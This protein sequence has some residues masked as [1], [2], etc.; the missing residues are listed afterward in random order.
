MSQSFVQNFQTL[1]TVL[2][3]S[4]ETDILLATPLKN[5]GQMA[6]F[7]RGQV[8]SPLLFRNA[9]LWLSEI[10]ESRFYRPDLW[11]YLDPVV[12]CEPQRVRL[13]CFSSCASVYGRVDF[14]ADFFNGYALQTRGTTHVNFNPAFIKSLSQLRPGQRAVLEVG[15]QFLAL[16]TETA[17]E[18]EVKVTLS[19]RW[20]RGFLQSQAL[21]RRA[22]LWKSL[23][24]LAARQFLLQL[25]ASDTGERCLCLRGAQLQSLPIRPTGLPE[26]ELLEVSG[27]HRLGLFRK[28]IPHLQSLDIYQTHANGPTLWVAHLPQ[29]RLTLALSSTVKHGFSGEGEA[30]RSLSQIAP[31]AELDFLRMLVAG[32]ESFTLEELSQLAEISIEQSTAWVDTLAS[33]GLLGFDNHADRYFYRVLPFVQARQ[34]RLENSQALF[35][36]EK[37]SLEQVLAL[38]GGL[39][40]QGWIQGQSAEYHAELALQGGYL[41]QGNCT[42]R[43]IQRHGLQRGPCKHLLALRF[44][45]EAHLAQVSPP[46]AGEHH[47]PPLA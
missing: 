36:Q 30:L 38:P 1:S 22:T 6:Q 43:W 17:R 47:A 42:C 10:V 3:H 7:F 34:G 44:A 26:A 33:E 40:A 18:I 35:S 8:R 27:L 13:E 2:S 4:E 21:F 5:P 25:K 45:A 32:L 19:E 31:Q 46:V 29:A 11:R 12:T 16:A 37:V 41:S 28:L 15:D 9:L 23:P 20:L 24:T 39:T 14:E